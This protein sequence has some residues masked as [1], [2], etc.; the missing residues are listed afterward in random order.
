[1]DDDAPGLLARALPAL[2]LLAL[3]ALLLAGWWLFPRFSAYMM[4]QNCVAS[5]HVNCGG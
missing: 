3:V 5:G 1:M 2:V 4:R